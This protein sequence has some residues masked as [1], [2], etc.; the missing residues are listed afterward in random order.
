VIVEPKDDSDPKRAFR[1]PFYSCE[2]LCC[3]TA[4][5]LDFF[6]PKEESEEEAEQ[7]EEGEKKES[8]KT[9]PETSDTNEVPKTEESEEAPEE[10][11]Q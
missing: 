10:C 9:K 3:D 6:F 2:L 1:Y 4:K 8:V 5:V 7:K 11:K